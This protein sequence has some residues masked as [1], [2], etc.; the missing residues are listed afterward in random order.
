ME[1]PVLF[2]HM[3]RRGIW[4]SVTSQLLKAVVDSGLAENMQRLYICVNDNNSLSNINIH[5]IPK[6]KVSFIRID[7][8]RT[9]WPTI[10]SL[11][12]LY[13]NVE[14]TPILYFHT[15]GVSV[16]KKETIPFVD[17]W[18]KYLSYFNITLWRDCVN[19][20]E[21]GCQAVGVNKIETPTPHYSGNFWWMNSS[22]LK[23]MID[24]NKENHSYEN[25][26]GNEFWIGRN[27]SNFLYN[28]YNP[29][30]PDGTQ[31]IVGYGN[32]LPESV[33]KKKY[34]NEKYGIFF[35]TNTPRFPDFQILNIKHKMSLVRSNDYKK[36]YLEYIV[37]NYDHLDDFTFFAQSDTFT[38]N[39]KE[40]METLKVNK[41]NDFGWIG[42]QTDHA[43]DK[44]VFKKAYVDLVEYDNI[45]YSDS[46]IFY[47]SKKFIHNSPKIKYEEMLMDYN[48]NPFDIFSVLEN[49]F[50]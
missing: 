8:T 21:I 42:E 24:P 40:F 12:N 33:Y 7:D 29:I 20:L 34:D 28:L 31:E 50:F 15:K 19:R 17:D 25:R 18:R 39:I 16:E 49:F 11:Y 9:E 38:K 22:F 45:K 32:S 6:E 26:Y 43:V 13:K 2:F 27:G 23:N 1:R 4:K 14:N 35:V 48:S 10:C 47:V 3:F 30:G 36:S 5:G 37:N 46:G 44:S 41:L